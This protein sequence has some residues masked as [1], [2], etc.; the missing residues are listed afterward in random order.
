MASNKDSSNAIEKIFQDADVNGTFV[1]YDVSDDRFIIH[2]ETRAER[3]F[4]PASTFKIPNSLIGLATSTVNDVDEILPYG[5]GPQF[6][7]IWEQDMGLRDA[8][9]VSNVPVYQELA[10]RIGLERM[11]EYVSMLDYGNRNIGNTVDRFWLEGPLQISAVEQAVFL[12][13][14]AQKKLPLPQQVQESVREIIEIE[15]GDGWSLYAKTGWAT[16]IQPSVGWWVGWVEKNG[17]IFSFALNIDMPEL[18]D[19]PKRKN[20][21]RACLQA[22]AIIE[23][24]NNH[25]QN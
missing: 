14:L 6:L 16:S 12:A 21:G 11:S 2:D 15:S 20:V 7:K 3:R 10:R 19:A 8:I 13:R 4:L 18:S 9:R 1:L 24:E 23:G 25:A 5:G 22:L 17:H